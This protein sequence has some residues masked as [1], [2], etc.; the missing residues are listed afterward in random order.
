MGSFNLKSSYYRVIGT[1][2][3]ATC[4][5]C[6]AFVQGA[7]YCYKDDYSTQPVPIITQC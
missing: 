5:S 3:V 7:K 4:A 1:N 6:D 2:G